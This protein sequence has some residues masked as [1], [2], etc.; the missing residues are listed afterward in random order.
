[1]TKRCAALSTGPYTHLDHLGPLCAALEI[2]LIVTEEH[3]YRL[4]QKFYPQIETVLKEE[5]PLDFLASSF[6]TL[7]GCGKFWALELLP[8]FELLYGKK[9]HLVFCPHGNSDKGHSVCTPVPQ[10]IALAYGQQMIDQWKKTGAQ[11]DTIITTG[12]IRYP[13]YRKHR[14]FYDE[15]AEKEVFSRLSPH[16]RTILYAPTWQDQENT[17]SFLKDCELLIEQLSSTYNLIVKLHPLL[18][19]RHPAETCHILTKYEDKQDVV[20]LTE[21]PPVYP[22][23]ARADLYLGDYSSIGYDFLAFDKPLFFLNPGDQS[24]FLHRCGMEIPR[25]EMTSLS[26]F[27]AEH[28]EYN[29]NHYS[30]AR[31]QTYFYA[32]G[33]EKE[34]QEIKNPILKEWG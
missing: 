25:K 16:K 9:M 3:T 34:E 10:D 11:I 32:F 18:E 22:L 14:H 4:A 31:K 28:L 23:L 26:A 21:F 19:E 33:K 27:I 6:D 5:L 13:F 2:P 12:N 7:F 15:I 1:M 30:E 29:Q 17:S 24:L 8:L 20:L